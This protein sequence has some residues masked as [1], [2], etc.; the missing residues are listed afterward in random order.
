MKLAC[1]LSNV[2]KTK[3]REGFS[4]LKPTP[5][6]LNHSKS[7]NCCYFQAIVSTSCWSKVMRIGWCIARWKADRKKKALLI[8]G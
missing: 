6:V 2:S 5:H 4:S 1:F 8:L 3:A 7:Y